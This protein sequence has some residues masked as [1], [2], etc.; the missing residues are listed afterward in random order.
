M[1]R[2]IR[3]GVSITLFTLITLYFLDFRELLPQSLHFLAKIQ[4][5]PALL[6]LNLIIL[7]SL[8]LLTFV[9]GRVYCSSICPMGIYQ[10]IVGW[11]SKKANRKKR[12]T[13]SPAKSILRWATLLL[14]TVA[15]IFG[16]T[17]LVGLLDPY[18]AYGRIVTHLFRPI[19]LAGNNLLET[20]FTQFNNYTFFR[21]S[22]Y[23]LS[24]LSTIIALFTLAGVGLLAWRN[25][26][27]FCNTLCPVGT[28]LGFISRLSLFKVQFDSE[29]C[30]SCGLCS[31]KC[32]AS[33]IDSKK[34]TVDYSRC[35]NCFNCIEACKRDAMH[36]K[37]IWSKKNKENEVVKRDVNQSKRRF[38]SATV[39]TGIAATSLLAQNSIEATTTNCSSRCAKYRQ[40]AP[41]MHL[42]SFVRYQMPISCYQTCTIRIWIRRNYATQTLFRSR[43]L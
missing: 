10:D 22:I 35:I 6:S 33:C 17:F 9:F 16:F 32:K 25:G 29:K 14:V 38:I 28:T 42:L 7:V 12:Y 2:K 4:F 34:L 26:R 31:M 27:T 13:Y 3:I 36:Y 21:V 30:N 39:T 19:Y 20:T 43:I 40:V 37:P 23:S 8:L 41:K 11:L 15:F 5:V 18:G 24:V 1:L